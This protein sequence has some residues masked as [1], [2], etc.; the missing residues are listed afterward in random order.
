M[1][2]KDETLFSMRVVTRMS[3]LTADTIRKWE[4]RYGAV[5]PRRTKGNTRK[6]TASDVRRLALLREITSRGPSIKEVAGLEEPELEKLLADLRAQAGLAAKGTDAQA[7]CFGWEQVRNDYMSAVSAFD[8][9][10]ARDLLS[11]AAGLLN[12][13]DF[14]HEVALPVLREVGELW[15]RGRVSPAHEHLAAMQIRQTLNS[16]LHFSAPP[17][18]APRIL[19]TTPEGH[20]HEL[21][22]MMGAVMAANRGLDPVYLGPDLPAGYI[23]AALDL[24][25]A[26]VLLLA[27]VRD[28]NDRELAGLARDLKTL[29]AKVDT[30]VGL[31]PDHALLNRK[32][33]A[34]FFTRFEDLDVALTQL[35]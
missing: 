23:R 33:G 13:T 15:S 14:I 27:V 8:I 16:I 29:S 32:I 6:Y 18:G 10:R 9:R 35:T 1:A 17:P 26:R 11:R 7:V 4:Q 31:P 3:G 25:R 5:Q 12:A 20:L 21:G 30:W 2:A 34:R 28:L 19:V 22:V 24:S